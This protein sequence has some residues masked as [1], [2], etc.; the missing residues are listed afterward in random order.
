VVELMLAAET[1]DDFITQ[2][3]AR[4]DVIVELAMRLVR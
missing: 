4:R 3:R 2:L 1:S